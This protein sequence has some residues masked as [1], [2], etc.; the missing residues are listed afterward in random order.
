MLQVDKK[1]KRKDEGQAAQCHEGIA[2]GL[3]IGLDSINMRLLIHI[4]IIIIAPTLIIYVKI[5]GVYTA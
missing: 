4:I 1:R 3:P 2:L 5:D